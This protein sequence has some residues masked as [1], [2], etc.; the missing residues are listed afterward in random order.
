V[1]EPAEYD[2]WYATRRG[3]WILAR[4]WRLVRRLLGLAA[5]ARVLDVGAGTGRFTALL[6]GAGLSPVAAE[7][8][9]GMRAFAAR[10]YPYLPWVGARAEALPF[11]DRAFDGVIAVTS[12]CFV[13]DEERALGELLRVSRGPVVLGLLNR[14]SRLYRLK[15]GQ[16]GYRG[17]RWHAPEQAR[18]L[19]ARVCPGCRVRLRSAIHRPQGG[20]PGRAL[21]TLS[22]A[23]LPGGGFLAVGIQRPPG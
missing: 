1:V 9:R 15:A 20:W 18:A 12:L 3:A 19:I 22:P 17:A 14:R 16:G 13:A 4:E 23:W 21:E 10:R 11:G 8:D 5:G 2:A 6:D 7:P